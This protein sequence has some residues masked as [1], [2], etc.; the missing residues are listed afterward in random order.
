MIE[1][2]SNIREN[3]L[4]L[5]SE[6]YSME[7]FKALPFKSDIFDSRSGIHNELINDMNDTLRYLLKDI[8]SVVSNIQSGD[9]SHAAY[10]L[11]EKVDTIKRERYSSKW[12]DQ[13]AFNFSQFATISDEVGVDYTQLTSR[14][15]NLCKIS[16]ERFSFFDKVAELMSEYIQLEPYLREVL[17]SPEDLEIYKDD[18]NDL[19]E[20]FG[21]ILKNQP[22]YIDYDIV[23]RPQIREFEMIRDELM[24]RIKNKKHDAFFNMSEYYYNDISNHAGDLA[25]FMLDKKYEDLISHKLTLTPSQK[26]QDF[27][28]FVD[29]SVC[30]K[31]G[32]EYKLVTDKEHYKKV[33]SELE[34]SIIDYQLRKKPKMANYISKLYKDSSYVGQLESV[35]IVIN[36]YLNNEQILKNMKL[37]LSIFESNSFESIDDHMNELINKHKL[38]QYANSILSNKNKHLLNDNSL[39]QF[40]VLMESGVSKSVIQNL[41]GKK[42]AAIHTPEEFEK[43]LEKVVEHVSGFS[44]EALMNKLDGNGIKPV[45][46]ENNVIVF[47]VKTFEQSKSLGSPSWCISRNEYYFNDYTSN[48]SKQYFLYDFNRTEKDNESMIGFT[49]QINGDLRTQ[50]AKNDDYHSVDDFL[51]KIVNKII[52]TNKQ[53]YQLGQEKLTE[54]E[55]EFNIKDKKNLNKVHSL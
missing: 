49:V 52:Y 2:Y 45:Y 48:D 46:N 12:S 47:E 41:V 7:K 23:I 34:H 15:E 54:L 50:H 1:K 9:Y 39:E 31:T 8:K 26:I 36:T 13:F 44:A 32:G 55:K 14:L 33:F 6:G 40:K 28:V 24:F 22:D 29:D 38:N 4:I 37:D 3:Y 11:K 21:T 35:L 16:K 10:G 53:D 19:V 18:I 25:G 27:V 17:Y 42:L 51:S 20:R 30:Y 43:Y 5:N